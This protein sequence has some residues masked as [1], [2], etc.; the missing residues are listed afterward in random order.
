MVLIHKSWCGACKQFGPMV[1]L[2]SEVEELS[3]ELI[4][5]NL[6]VRH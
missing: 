5:I 1:A 4:M 2:S 3:K 6:L